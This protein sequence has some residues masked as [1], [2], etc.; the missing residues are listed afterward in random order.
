M[1]LSVAAAVVVLRRAVPRLGRGAAGRLVGLLLAMLPLGLLISTLT[2][3]SIRRQ[4]GGADR[5]VPAGLRAVGLHLRDRQH[6]AADPAAH[7]CCCRRAI[8]S[9]ACRRCSWPAT[10]RGAG[11]RTRWPW[12][13]SR[14]VL[15]V[16]LVARRPGCGWS[17]AMWQR[18]RIADRQ[19]AARRAGATRKSR[20]IL[21]V[22][23]L[24]Q[25]LV[26][27]FAATQEVKN[28][29][30]GGAQPATWARTR[31]DLVARFEG[32]PNFAAVRP[33]ARRGRD[34]PGDRLA[35]RADGAAHSARTFRASWPPGGRPRCSCSWTAGARTRRRSSRATPSAI[36]GDYNRELAA[37]RR[38]PPPPSVRRRRGSGSIPTSRRTWNTVPSLVGDPDDADGPGGD[39]A[40][41]GPRARAG[42]VRA[43]AGLAAEPIEIIIGKT[44]PALLIGIGRGDAA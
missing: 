13:R 39:G 31:R 35:Q 36:V 26:F 2:Q 4:P 41:G 3:E 25:M 30:I 19:G 6:A 40:V 21:I 28:V 38:G 12:R 17:N 44:V 24:V 22:P 16:L 32:S 14:R 20:M 7:L 10:W 5:G 27:A 9:P 8:S 15:L 37:A 23:P 18:I 29:R 34:R 11:A 33:P 42:H 43:V 1:A